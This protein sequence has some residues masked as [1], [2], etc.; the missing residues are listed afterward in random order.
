[1]WGFLTTGQGYCVHFATAMAIM[2][3]SVGI[4]M[5][6]S[7]GFLI[8]QSSDGLWSGVYGNQAH[9]WPEAYYPEVG[10][11]RYEPTPA[12]PLPDERRE[13]V[14][15]PVP[16]PTNEQSLPAPDPSATTAEP[17]SSP[18]HRL[19]VDT[20][21]PQGTAGL[22]GAGVAFAGLAGVVGLLVWIRTY[23]LERAWRRIMR[24]GVRSGVLTSG[25]T[26]RQVTAR[27]NGLT[28][29]LSEDLT[30]LRDQLEFARYGLPAEAD[31]APPWTGA[32]L[33]LLTG[34]IISPLRRYKPLRGTDSPHLVILRSEATRRI[35]TPQ[36]DN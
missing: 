7:A 8:R 33:F 10:W 2:A 16:L 22:W 24:R 14:V 17:S 13:P 31:S 4:P 28:P 5:R 15:I 1:V 19:P 27:L 6:V 36:L 35:Q 26:V 12:A 21:S 18:T 32:R 29:Q 23:H 9:L 34:R 20:D 3:E 25:M 30:V 11:V